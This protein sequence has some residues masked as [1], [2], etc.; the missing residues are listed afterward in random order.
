MT[1]NEW[2]LKPESL[3]MNKETK[4]CDIRRKAAILLTKEQKLNRKKL[5]NL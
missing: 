1:I 2:T 5:L 3:E 4:P